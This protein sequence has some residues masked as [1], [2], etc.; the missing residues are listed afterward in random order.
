[1]T[2]VDSRTEGSFL[3]TDSS[4]I[5]AQTVQCGKAELVPGRNLHLYVLASFVWEGTLQ[6]QKR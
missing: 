3:Q 6:D 2:Q 5:S 1:M 4:A